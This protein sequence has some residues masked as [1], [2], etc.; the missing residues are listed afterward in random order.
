MDSELQIVCNYIV[1]SE[2]I[3][4]S[5]GTLSHTHTQM[6]Y[7]KCNDFLRGRITNTGVLVCDLRVSVNNNMR[8]YVYV[9]ARASDLSVCQEVRS[10]NQVQIMSSIR[11]KAERKCMCL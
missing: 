1:L 5:A 8:G 3:S 9:R 10:N 7:R 4:A 6:I 11:M 2:P